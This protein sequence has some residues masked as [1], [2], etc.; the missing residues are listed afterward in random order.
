[1]ASIQEELKALGSRVGRRGGERMM[2]SAWG[3][4]VEVWAKIKAYHVE[5]APEGPW[6]L[7]CA[8]QAALKVEELRHKE[9]LEWRMLKQAYVALRL[10]Y[11]PCARRHAPSSRARLRQLCASQHA[12]EELA[13]RL[14]VRASELDGWIRGACHNKIEQR[15]EIWLKQGDSAFPDAHHPELH[16]RRER[17]AARAE[18]NKQKLA[19][20]PLPLMLWSDSLAS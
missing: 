14:G 17:A 1:M 18:A 2:W 9:V 4:V 6:A 20:E 13:R 10:A 16:A 19:S 7:Y 8:N 11:Q 15:V 12:Q 3:D 5:I